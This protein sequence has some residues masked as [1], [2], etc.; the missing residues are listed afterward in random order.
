MFNIKIRHGYN[1]IT[2]NGSIP[3]L[4]MK[5]NNITF[6]IV[7]EFEVI[8]IFIFDVKTQKKIISF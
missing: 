7:K 3:C 4:E 6:S 2:N 1:K 8:Y 5:P